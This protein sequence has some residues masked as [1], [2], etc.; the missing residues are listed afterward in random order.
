MDKKVR[1]PKPFFL[2]GSVPPPSTTVLKQDWINRW[3]NQILQILKDCV[4]LFE[5]AYFWPSR[6][7]HLE[8]SSPDH[9]ARVLLLLRGDHNVPLMIVCESGGEWVC[10]GISVT[11]EESSPA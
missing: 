11:I 8:P 7:R 3:G 10:L 6:S 2:R 5:Y 9:G 4:R 1:I